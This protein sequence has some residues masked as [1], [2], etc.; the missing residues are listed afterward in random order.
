MK[1]KYGRMERA[2]EDLS[3]KTVKSEK[4][5]APDREVSRNTP[6]EAE[7]HPTVARELNA[8]IPTW[9]PTKN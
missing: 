9:D 3:T 1:E 8:A 2:D 6:G 4:Q 5:P 7:L